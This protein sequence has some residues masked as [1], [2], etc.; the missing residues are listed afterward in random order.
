MTSLRGAT[1]NRHRWLFDQLVPPGCDTRLAIEDRTDGVRFICACAGKRTNCFLPD[2]TAGV[3]ASE[4]LGWVKSS[5]AAVEKRAGDSYHYR[6]VLL[7]QTQSKL[8]NYVIFSNNC[9]VSCLSRVSLL[10]ILI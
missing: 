8:K 6:V 4:R 10:I 7:S 9:E 5:P 1:G 3:A 2:P